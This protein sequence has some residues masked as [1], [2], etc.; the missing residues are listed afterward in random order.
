MFD[1]TTT[2]FVHEADMIEFNPVG[3]E[4]GKS[5][6]NYLRIGNHLFKYDDVVA[7]YKNPYV[8]A[9][10]AKLFIDIDKFM[11]DM[12]SEHADAK[13]FKLDFY[14]RRSGDNNSFYS[15]AFVFKGKDFHYEWTNKENTAALVRKMINKIMKLYGDVYNKIYV[16]DG[17]LV[18]EN[19]NYGLFTEAKLSVYVPQESDC[20]TYREG[21]WEVISELIFKCAS[22]EGEECEH[23][24]FAIFSDEE[25]NQEG[26]YMHAEQGVNGF[27][28]YEQLLKDL[29]LPTME[30]FRWTSLNESEMPVPGNKYVQYT[31]HQISCRGVLGGSAVGEVTHSKTTHVFFVPACGCGEDLSN[32]LDEAIEGAGMKDKVIDMANFIT[33]AEL[34]TD[35]MDNTTHDPTIK[36]DTVNE[37][38]EEESNTSGS[39]ETPDSGETPN[40]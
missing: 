17:K 22:E 3:N 40:P 32:L 25:D 8:P 13:R 27:G 26:K 33:V 18:F 9:R 20:C 10:N 23:V 16:E 2:T 38:Y 37:N 12:K 19:D 15:N 5:S 36:A 7:I 14:I 35:G 4:E 29:R 1:F 39:S 11:T 21:G 24:N 6:K 31:F 30:N 34:D 28:T